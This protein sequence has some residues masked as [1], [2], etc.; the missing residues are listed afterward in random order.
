MPVVLYGIENCDTMKK[1]R[2]WLDTHKVDY[3]FHDYN[4]AGIAREGRLS[5][6]RRQAGTT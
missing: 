1:A 3:A 5:G 4:S 6:R 2:A